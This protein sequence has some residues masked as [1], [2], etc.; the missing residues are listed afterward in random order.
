MRELKGNVSHYLIMLANSLSHTAC[1]ART[2][3]AALV[4]GLQKS[5]EEYVK[6]QEKNDVLS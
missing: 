1:V 3:K 6:T 5:V 4:L 2:L